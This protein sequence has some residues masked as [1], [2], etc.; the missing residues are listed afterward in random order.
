MQQQLK[1]KDTFAQGI[2]D[3]VAHTLI[4]EDE[5]VFFRGDY[6][7]RIQAPIITTGNEL[8]KEEIDEF[9]KQ[10]QIDALYEYIADVDKG[11][12]EIFGKAKI[13]DSKWSE[14]SHGRVYDT[15]L[16]MSDADYLS[17]NHGE[18]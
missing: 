8:G 16:F 17:E 10:L 9:S 14:M 12:T 15:Y 5:Q 2:E 1:K 6:Q 13:M 4:A 11:T 18:G 3:I 7:R